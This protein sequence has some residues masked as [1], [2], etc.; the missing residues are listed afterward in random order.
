MCV[1]S[2]VAAVLVASILAVSLAG[3]LGDGP[4]SDDGLEPSNDSRIDPS[5]EAPGTEASENRSKP[6]GPEVHLPSGYKYTCP[7]GGSTRPEDSFCVGRV[8]RRDEALQEPYLVR[9]PDDS[10]RLALGLN[11]GQ[12]LDTA[13]ARGPGADLFPVE[14]FVSEDGGGSWERRSPPRTAERPGPGALW[15]AD[16]ALAFDDEG[17]LHATFQSGYIHEPGLTTN[18]TILYTRSPDHGASWSDPVVLS[19]DG[20]ESIDDRNWVSVGPN[21]TVVVAW[22]DLAR[23]AVEIAWSTDD[24]DSW[25]AQ[26]DLASV[27]DCRTVTPPVHHEGRFLL[28]C[29]GTNASEGSGSTRLLEFD[30]QRGNAST[31]TTL[32]DVVGEYPRLVETAGGA[33]FLVASDPD[34]GGPV[35][36]VRSL[37]GGGTWSRPVDLRQ[38]AGVEDDWAYVHV[39]AWE[40]DPWGGVHLLIGGSEVRPQ[41]VFNCRTGVT[42]DVAHVAI[43][44]VRMEI[45]AERQLTSPLPARPGIPPS[46]GAHPCNDDF[47]GLTFGPGGGLAAWTRDRGIDLAQV[48]PEA[49]TASGVDGSR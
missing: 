38:V 10:R 17:M 14:I 28:A 30:A 44:P 23:G 49:G 9:D 40:P 29:Q 27:P 12:T 34:T 25:F 18:D 43:D 20:P 13:E 32:E 1:P 41:P 35:T 31:V 42:F 47:Y 21:G 2:R 45:L 4:A 26:E 37:D 3:C 24:G 48:V 39:Y 33:L 11:T 8:S 19:T 36:V 6:E 22:M 16:P 15:A 5:E 46:A 7:P